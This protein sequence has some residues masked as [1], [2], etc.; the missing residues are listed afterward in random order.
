MDS[1]SRTPG[2]GR[3][4][5]LGAAQA[6]QLSELGTAEVRPRS[7]A[8]H[9]GLFPPSRFVGRVRFRHTVSGHVCVLG[10]P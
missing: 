9:R 1:V 10:P 8:A 4:R 7:K 2:E 5:V 6:R 3:T